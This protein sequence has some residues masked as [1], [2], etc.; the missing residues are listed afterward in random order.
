M[1][2]F[3]CSLVAGTSNVRALHRKLNS[4]EV[5]RVRDSVWE[6]TRVAAQR[7]NHLQHRQQGKHAQFACLGLHTHTHTHTHTERD[8]C[9]ASEN[10]DFGHQERSR[11]EINCVEV[12]CIARKIISAALT[13]VSYSDSIGIGKGN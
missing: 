11:Q 5:I 10:I 6:A 4:H 7:K 9:L 1:S 12:V 2:G 8:V 13:I 3:L